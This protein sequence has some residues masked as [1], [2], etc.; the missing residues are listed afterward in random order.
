MISAADRHALLG[1]AGGGG[2]RVTDSR[3][4]GARWETSLDGPAAPAD[5]GAAGS[6]GACFPRPATCWA[7][8][9]SSM[10]PSHP[11]VIPA[12]SRSAMRATSSARRKGR[13]GRRGSVSRALPVELAGRSRQTRRGDTEPRGP[14]APYTM[15][16]SD[17][18]IA[19]LTRSS[20]TARSTRRRRPTALA[21]LSR[22]AAAPALSPTDF[23]DWSTTEDGLSY[24]SSASRPSS[25]R[26]SG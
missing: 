19:F 14:R 16:S 5:F 1:E 17:F 25:R 2:H 3:A 4:E 21:C 13:A 12:L 8:P 7:S 22:R 26:E 15:S 20:S 23:G 24:W 18:D 11:A 10:T 6:T 9:P